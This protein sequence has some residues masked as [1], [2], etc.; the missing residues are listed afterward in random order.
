MEGILSRL[1]SIDYG[2]KR[3]G[4]AMTDP[5]K[6]FANPYITIKNIGLK[7]ILSE[8]NDIICENSIEKVIVG[9]PLN[10][11]GS[12]SQK[13]LEVRKFFSELSKFILVPSVLFDERYSTIEANDYLKEKGFTVKESREIIDQIAA[14]VIL[15]SY[16]EF[17]KS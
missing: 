1:M 17:D 9:L 2:E 6:L 13:T 16:L 15:R 7:H 10:L 12:D 14:A 3:I 5:L 4:I 8:I 11:E